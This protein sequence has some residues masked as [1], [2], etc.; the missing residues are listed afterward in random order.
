MTTLF[1]RAVIDLRQ[2]R[3]SAEELEFTCMSVFANITFLVPEGA[4]VRP[5]GMAILGSSKC[6]VPE[7]DQPSALPAMSVDATTIFGR[8]RIR[9]TDEELDDET[10]APAA[11][12]AAAPSEHPGEASPIHNV[13]VPDS[14]E[15][16]GVDAATNDLEPVAY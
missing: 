3:T 2:A 11:T 9:T 4:E 16:A 10:E 15:G 12:R 14:L 13:E 8:L 7:S 5:S 6:M 1:G